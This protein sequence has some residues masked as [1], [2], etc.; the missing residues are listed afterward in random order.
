MNGDAWQVMA[1][2]VRAAKADRERRLAGHEAVVASFEALL[3]DRDLS[4]IMRRLLSDYCTDDPLPDAARPTPTRWGGRWYCA[5]DGTAMSA[6]DHLLPMCPAC[7]RIL[8]NGVL[9]QLVEIHQHR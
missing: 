2:A 4:P 7:D 1:E 8:S 5:L 3:F 6:P 9:Y